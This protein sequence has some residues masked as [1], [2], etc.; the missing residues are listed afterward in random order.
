MNQ[1]SDL[2]CRGGITI[3]LIILKRIRMNESVRIV[4][5]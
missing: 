5:L 3:V 2:L 4:Y 1:T